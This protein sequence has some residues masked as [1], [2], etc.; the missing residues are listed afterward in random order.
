M[1]PKRRVDGFWWLCCRRKKKTTHVYLRGYPVALQIRRLNGPA[2]TMKEVVVDCV[3]RFVSG[4]ADLLK[5]TVCS[6]RW[7]LVNPIRGRDLTEGLQRGEAG[8]PLHLQG[9]DASTV[10]RWC[11][12]CRIGGLIHLCKGGQVSLGEQVTYE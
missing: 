5:K 11:A 7:S 12:R 4:G 8:S 10:Q 1:A 2:A 6:R 3:N 9:I